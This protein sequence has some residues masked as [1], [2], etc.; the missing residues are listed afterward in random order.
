MV[1]LGFTIR[2]LA[3]ELTDYIHGTDFNTIEVHEVELIDGC[4]RL[5]IKFT[6]ANSRGW[7]DEVLRV[8]M[9]EILSWLACREPKED[10]LKHF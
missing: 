10:K 3:Y 9:W 8:N 5:E 4:T 2:D 6:I 7:K 1:R